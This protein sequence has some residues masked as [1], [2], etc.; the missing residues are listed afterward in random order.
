MGDQANT[1]VLGLPRSR[2]REVKSSSIR[3]L[4]AA[5]NLTGPNWK[6]PTSA[7]ELRSQFFHCS[8]FQDN[9]TGVS[10]AQGDLRSD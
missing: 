9:F 6:I 8:I 3:K 2:C 7:I 1:Y 5:T 4:Q 10:T